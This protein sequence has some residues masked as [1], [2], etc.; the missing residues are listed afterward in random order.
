MKKIHVL[1]AGTFDLLHPG[2]IHY[3]NQAARKGTHLTVVVARD[4][5]VKKMKGRFPVFTERHRLE[6]VRALKGVDHAVFGGSNGRMLDVVV[7]L[8]PDVIALGYD[9]WPNEKVMREALAE[10]G[11]FPR[12]VRLRAVKP[13]VWKSSYVRAHMV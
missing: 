10:K 3:L 1:A 5:T 12:I 4:S 2:H 13:R 11:L 6:L 9:Q 8:K 7:K